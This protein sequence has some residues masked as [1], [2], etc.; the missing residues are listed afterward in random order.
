[1]TCI[2]VMKGGL[3]G[4]DGVV[5]SVGMVTHLAPMLEQLP[6]AMVSIHSWSDYRHVYDEVMKHQDDL[7]VVIGYSGGGMKATWVANGWFNQGSYPSAALPRPRIDLLVTYDPSPRYGMM[8]LHSNVKAAVNY[9][10]RTP[11][12]FGLGGGILKSAADGPKVEVIDVSEQHLAIQFNKKLHRYT[13]ER[14]R[15]LIESHKQKG[16]DA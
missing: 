8:D 12:M 10:N 4:F 5:T 9:Y 2:F 7:I 1:M 15:A 3:V 13:V 6:G 11:L 14:I 16:R